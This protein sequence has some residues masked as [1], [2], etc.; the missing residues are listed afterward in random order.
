MKG[1]IRAPA[2]IDQTMY[3]VIIVG[4]SFAGLAVANQLRD[5][6]VLLIDR[7]LLGTGQTSACGTVLQVLRYWDLQDTVLQTH[8]RLMLHT[9]SGDHSFPSPYAW[10]TFDYPQLCEAL[11]TRSKAEFLQAAV[12]GTDGESVYTSEGSYSARCNVDA[13]G[14][15]AVLANSLHSR[16]V[17]TGSM[18]FGIET[19]ARFPKDPEF[20]PGSLHFWYDPNILSRGVGW[21]F[22]RGETASVGVGSYRGATHLRDPLNNLGI[23]YGVKSNG[24]HGTYFPSSLR[25]VSCS[26]V[27]VVGDAAGMCIGLTGEGIRPALFFGEACGR[28][29]RQSLD[30]KIT[31]Q[32]AHTKYTSFV[33]KHRPFF[34]LFSTLQGLLTQLPPKWIDYIAASIRHKRV[35]PWILDQYWSLTQTWGVP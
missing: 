16:F 33:N 31:L 1:A 35:L 19:I 9:A 10:C 23:R 6:R 32:T 8:D 5:H 2:Y 18:N 14:W 13:S 12:L 4:A 17:N 7:K 24:F 20:D 25:P 28:I 26:Q 27:F 34:Q 30:K 15:R 11:F 3:D 22:P 21:I 29:V